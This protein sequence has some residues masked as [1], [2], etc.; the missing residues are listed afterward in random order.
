MD[1][2]WRG[3]VARARRSRADRER[4]ASTLGV[5]STC[6]GET[7]ALI[8]I[9]YEQRYSNSENRAESPLASITDRRDCMLSSVAVGLVVRGMYGGLTTVTTPKF[10]Y[11]VSF[12]F[13]SNY[14]LEERVRGALGGDGR[15]GHFRA[16]GM[17]FRARGIGEVLGRC[18]P[19][20]AP[21]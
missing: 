3:N 20:L 13:T 11:R 10:E 14:F 19:L 9:R 6:C 1:L 7:V 17:L 5:Y 2:L 18:L 8:P 15:S 16:E 21:S 4:A 12:V